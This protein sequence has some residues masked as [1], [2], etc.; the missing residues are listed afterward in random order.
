MVVR[1][2]GR[3]GSFWNDEKKND[4]RGEGVSYPSRV[5]VSKAKKS[6]KWPAR[7]KRREEEKRESSRFFGGWLVEHWP[8]TRGPDEGGRFGKL[9]I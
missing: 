2:G 8:M 6:P 7:G 3:G 9:Y 4:Q 1:M 5:Q